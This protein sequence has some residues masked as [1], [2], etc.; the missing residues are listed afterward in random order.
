[1]T[2]RQVYILALDCVNQGGIA[3]LTQIRPSEEHGEEWPAK[4]RK[5]YDDE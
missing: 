5:G 2:K 3:M 4:D 1:M